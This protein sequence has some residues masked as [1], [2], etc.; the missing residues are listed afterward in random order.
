MQSIG[1]PGLSRLLR[2]A[3]KEWRYLSE[4][5]RIFSNDGIYLALLLSGGLLLASLV[6]SWQRQQDQF[7]NKNLIEANLLNT[8]VR[9][10]MVTAQDW[11]QRQSTLDVLASRTP[12]G[13]GQDLRNSTIIRDGQ[14]LLLV[15]RS[16]QVVFDSLANDSSN[17]LSPA[18]RGAVRAC[19]L[20][21]LRWLS[22]NTRPQVR[23]AY[24][25]LCRSEDVLVV[26]GAARGAS[27]KAKETSPGW[28]V[29]YGT[30]QTDG[31]REG[32]ASILGEIAPK[33]S[34]IG[35]GTA[36]TL[37][38]IGNNPR[39]VLEYFLA[40]EEP[41]QL[42]VLQQP[43]VIKDVISGAFSETLLPWATV[44]LALLGL[45][46]A[47]LSNARR[48]RLQHRRD[49]RRSHRLLHNYRILDQGNDLLSLP[50]FL[51][52]AGRRDERTLGQQ[53]SAVRL[54]GDI[55]A[56]I[57]TFSLDT[58]SQ[59]STQ[60]SLMADLHERLRELLPE[61][62]I[63]RT[64]DNSLALLTLSG[65]TD[66]SDVV[67][68]LESAITD[69]RQ[70]FSGSVRADIRAALTPLEPSIVEKQISDLSILNRYGKSDKTVVLLPS[71]E[72]GVLTEVRR[73]ISGD[74]TATSFAEGLQDVSPH[75]EDVVRI[76]DGHRTICYREMLFRFPKDTQPLMQVQELILALERNNS[77]HL[78]DL[79]M[80]RKAIHLLSNHRDHELRLGANLSAQTV[81]SSRHREEITKILREVPAHTRKNLI[82]EVTETAII[83]GPERWKGF[84]LELGSLGV[85]VSIDDFGS[86]YASL[87]HLFEFHADFIKVD[88]KYTRMVPNHEVNAMVSFLLSFE[89]NSA[90]RVIMEGIE[91]EEQLNHWLGVG[92]SH[93]QGFL[94]TPKH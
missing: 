91:T 38:P 41:G 46:L 79:L 51:D 20:E 14:N 18:A 72:D 66:G 10:H 31:S 92:V 37:R 54:V 55:K 21:R 35:S 22:L 50:A 67:R 62:R 53:G 4:S 81:Q 48:I 80:L 90:T 84:L 12:D 13:L 73:K 77:I 60:S 94:F 57:H 88:M 74:F 58:E 15:D 23:D 30:T 45:T 52:L 28:I 42:W 64:P 9:G 71:S 65:S 47:S 89:V 56:T 27:A 83:G 39:T 68:A 76:V 17:P 7:R 26:G 63:C 3:R 19:L 29:Q 78:I 44:N 59:I 33:L 32:G 16:A 36:Q 87:S 75:L 82:L 24:G 85:K 43:V 70:K 61:A 34:R 25:L 86:G 93:F 2:S 49:Q 6:L 11:S 40:A 1:S 8:R 5:R 69:T